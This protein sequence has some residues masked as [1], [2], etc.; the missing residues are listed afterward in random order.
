[1]ETNIG[2]IHAPLVILAAGAWS[3]QL[4][5]PYGVELPVR[6]KTIQVHFY[7]RPEGMD[8]PAFIDDTTD[9][10]ARPDA[11]GISLVGYPVDEWDIDP[12]ERR[13]IM[14]SHLMREVAPTRLSWF[15]Q[16]QL[17]GGRRSFDGYSTDRKGILAFSS[18]LEGLLFATGWS[19]GGFKVAPGVG[20]R[21]AD[22]I[23]KK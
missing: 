17:A 10:Y 21:T 6:S 3:Q 19:G 22:L 11:R 5:Q 14:L 16:A 12:D 23:L 20:E 15:E 18:D 8:H 7:K 13:P 1:M 9:L 4:V 2:T